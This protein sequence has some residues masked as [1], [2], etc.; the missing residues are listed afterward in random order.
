MTLARPACR[1][2]DSDAASPPHSPRYGASVLR[3]L[4]EN[5]GVYVGLNG[6]GGGRSRARRRSFEFHDC[7]DA[8]LTGIARDSLDGRPARRRRQS[9]ES[10][11]VGRAPTRNRAA[12]PS[13]AGVSAAVTGLSARPR[14]LRAACEPAGLESDRRRNRVPPE[15]Q[16]RDQGSSPAAPA[17]ANLGNRHPSSHLRGDTNLRIAMNCC[18][19][20]P[21]LPLVLPLLAVIRSLGMGRTDS[22][23]GSRCHHD[24]RLGRE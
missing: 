14:S 21:R 12:S 17:S 24:A 19:P 18:W 23:F 15:S 4:A 13:V 22:S 3:C 11:P 9:P 6:F 5:S 16:R 1:T 7:G 10:G 8:V 2:C 20:A